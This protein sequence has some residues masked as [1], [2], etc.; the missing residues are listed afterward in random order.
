MPGSVNSCPQPYSNCSH[1]GDSSEV[2]DSVQ[3]RKTR[4]VALSVL[5][6]IAIVGAICAMS[7]AIISLAPASVILGAMI[8]L[9]LINIALSVRILLK[10][11]S[12]VVVEHKEPTPEKVET[13]KKKLGPTKPLF[14]TLEYLNVLNSFVPVPDPGMGT[15]EHTTPGTPFKTWRIPHTTTYLVS[16]QGSISAPLFQTTGLSPMIANAAN[17]HMTRGGGGTNRALTEATHAA[18]WENSKEQRKALAVGECTAAN[19][20]NPDGYSNDP[21]GAGPMFL[22]QVLGP[23]ASECNNDPNVCYQQT[24]QAYYSLLKK[25][26]QNKSHLVQL[27]LLSSGHYAPSQGS[28]QFAPWINASKLALLSAIQTFGCSNPAYPII[29]VLTNVGTPIF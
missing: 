4:I 25:A 1:A 8:A 29:V 28:D 24:F 12:K 3:I 21:T 11:Q 22:A 16:T 19:W 7:I 27:P 10:R 18:C 9:A 26:R 5:A 2:R 6:A 17:R 14:T 15:F 20:I 13:E 23:N